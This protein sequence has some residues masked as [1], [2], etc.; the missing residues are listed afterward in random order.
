VRG[1]LATLAA[2]AALVA[3]PAALA[4]TGTAPTAPVYDGK[5]HLV[6]TPFAPQKPQAQL[7]R[8]RALEAFERFPKV[9]AWLSRYPVAATRRRTTRR[10]ASGR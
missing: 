2:F 8:K 6:Q 5:G 1:L 9:K 10:P 7:D 4:S 3:A